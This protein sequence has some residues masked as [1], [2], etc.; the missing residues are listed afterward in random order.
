MKILN[1]GNVIVN[2]YLVEL[3]DGYLLIDTGYSNGYKRFMEKL[4]KH[5]ISAQQ[6]K[7]IFITHAH[8]DHIGFLDELLKNLP[9]ITLITNSLSKKRF[10]EGHNRFVGGCTSLRS[11]MF[12]KVMG[13]MGKGKHEFPIVNYKLYKTIDCDNLDNLRAY[14]INADIIHLQGHTSDHRGLLFDDGRLFCGDA[15]MNGFPSKHHIIIFVEDLDDYKHTWNKILDNKKIVTLYPAHG[16]PFNAKM[17]KKNRQYL[18]K[19][20]LRELKQ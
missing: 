5:R 2:Q 1:L 19:I 12:C 20:K 16:K 15:V 6:I 9:H 3:N 7:Y 10:L 17:I 11:S 18:D 8:D 4:S 14:G 13:V